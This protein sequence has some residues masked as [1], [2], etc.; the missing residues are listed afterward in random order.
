MQ[1]RRVFAWVNMQKNV[2][3]FGR[4]SFT[5]G[6]LTC[7]IMKITGVANNIN[8]SSLLFKCP[9]EPK[10]CDSE[11]A[12]TISGAV[13]W[14]LALTD[15]GIHVRAFPVTCHKVFH[16]KK[17]FWV[18]LSVFVSSGRWWTIPMKKQGYNGTEYLGTR[19][20]RTQ[21][22]G[23]FVHCMYNANSKQSGDIM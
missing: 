9:C 7:Q 21:P 4:L 20:P 22:R 19:G 8:N 17:A 1:L 12:C 18:M 3:S 23:W 5:A 15:F 6:V 10:Q 2:F 16:K 13:K 14:N 11:S